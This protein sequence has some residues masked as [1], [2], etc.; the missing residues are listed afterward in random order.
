[1]IVTYKNRLKHYMW[2]TTNTVDGKAKLVEAQSTEKCAHLQLSILVKD[3]TNKD[4][5]WA[6]LWIISKETYRYR[7]KHKIQ[8]MPNRTNGRNKKKKHYNYQWSLKELK[9]KRL[10]SLIK[11]LKRHDKGNKKLSKKRLVRD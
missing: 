6:R 8:W 11:V 3:S 2:K 5:R 10:K 7:N 9:R 1:M 4:K